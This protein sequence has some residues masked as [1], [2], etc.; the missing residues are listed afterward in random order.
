MIWYTVD[1]A[2]NLKVSFF[3]TYSHPVITVMVDWALNQLFIYLCLLPHYY[4]TVCKVLY[5]LICFQK[6]PNKDYKTADDSGIH[7]EYVNA[8]YDT[9][10]KAVSSDLCYTFGRTGYDYQ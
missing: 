7:A 10:M 5:P 1:Y 9:L 3:F 4:R 6:D 8:V 2:L